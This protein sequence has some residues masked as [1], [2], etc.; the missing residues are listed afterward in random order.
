MA[1]KV[2]A[3]ARRHRARVT[4]HAPAGAVLERINPA[5]GVV[6]ALDAHT[7]V[8]DTGA[9][10]PD[11]LAVHL[12]MLGYDF[13]VTEPAELVDHLRALAGR[14]ARAV[15]VPPAPEPGPPGQSSPAASSR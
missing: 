10:S 7:C 2:P 11:S 13:T 9:D 8:L 4:V 14:Y 5:V 15:P 1:G 6:E 12:G 3:A